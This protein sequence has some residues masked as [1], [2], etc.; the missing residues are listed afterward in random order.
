MPPVLSAFAASTRPTDGFAPRAALPLLLIAFTGVLFAMKYGPRAGIPPWAGLAGYLVFFAVHVFIASR[1]SA[2]L[3]EGRR[4][5]GVARGIVFAGVAVYALAM[6]ALYL[7][8]DPMALQIDRSSQAVL[9]KAFR[10]EL[11]LAKES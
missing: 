7:R 1:L 11:L 3:G 8:I 4:A 2:R 5:R 10:G 9:A 6:L